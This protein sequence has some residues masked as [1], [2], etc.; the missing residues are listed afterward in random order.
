MASAHASLE[1]VARG[2]AAL[3]QLRLGRA[4]DYLAAAQAVAQE[5]S[6]SLHAQDRAA[7]QRLDWLTHFVAMRDSPVALEETVQVVPPNFPALEA[8]AAK[9]MPIDWNNFAAKVA[10]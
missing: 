7:R 3:A 1:Q 5:V 8:E 4:E 10:T 9:A 6:D 2:S